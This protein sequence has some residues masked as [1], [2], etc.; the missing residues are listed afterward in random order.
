M[1][2]ITN[3][4]PLL[5]VAVAILLALGLIA[6]GFG[7]VRGATSKSSPTDA[8]RGVVFIYSEFNDGEDDW[9]ASG[10]GF[11]V[12]V[13]GQ[14]PRYVVTNG[15]VIEE[16]DTYDGEI[17]VY[18]DALHDDY[19][20]PTIAWVDYRKDLAILDLGT[21][22]DKRV[23]L[24]L[25]F[26]DA[27]SKGEQV[28]ALGYPGASDSSKTF[29]PKDGSD[30]TITTGIVGEI[31]ESDRVHAIQTDADVAPGNSGGPLVNAQGDVVGINTWKSLETG[32]MTFAVAIDEIVPALD[33]V[34]VAY[35][36]ANHTDVL[37]MV[38][39][40]VGAVLV[41]FGLLLGLML[42]R[43]RRRL[44]DERAASALSAAAAA[45]ANALAAADTATR[46]A[47]IAAQA[48]AD[49]TA[50]KAAADAAIAAAAAQE[51]VRE[52]MAEAAR[53][54]QQAAEMAAQQ[55]AQ[56]AARSEAEAAQPLFQPVLVGLVGQFAGVSFDLD[57][58]LNIG[59]DASR[60]NLVFDPD[61]P[62]VS[63]LHCSVSYDRVSERFKLEDHRS[64][65]GTFFGAGQRIDPDR[66]AFL[67]AG[68]SFYLASR[69]TSFQVA[70]RPES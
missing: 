2:E 60:C 40:I 12:G 8:M 46:N 69:D 31:I 7:I 4:A 55:A 25:L 16:G 33:E 9:I 20:V 50:A 32:S 18:F 15:H 43:A 63:G 26:R 57:T 3:R 10:T 62:G 53:R 48:V 37:T 39:T 36:V 45:H 30:I 42:L 70:F 47:A 14:N 41:I 54:A 19:I 66:P 28:Y 67:A 64:T 51:V 56:Q 61:V 52:E 35:S 65:Y 21:T 6:I 1:K 49:A 38:C 17:R 5:K 68:D 59:R 22:T 29:S 44:A 13:R 24:P 34:G 58:R 11:F 27:V 23:A